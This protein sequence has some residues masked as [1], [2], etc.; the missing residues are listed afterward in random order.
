MKQEILGKAIFAGLIVLLFAWAAAGAPMRLG[1]DLQGGVKLMVK[2]DFELS[3]TEKADREGKERSE[4][5]YSSAERS[6]MMENLKAVL[7]RRLN[8]T[9][10]AEVSIRQRGKDKFQIEVPGANEAE[11]ERLRDVIERRGTLEFMLMA[12]NDPLTGEKIDASRFQDVTDPDELPVTAG[13]NAEPGWEDFI[14]KEADNP[15]DL[16][17]RLLGVHSVRY[18]PLIRP[19]KLEPKAEL[20]GRDL[21]LV[22]RT[23]DDTGAPAIAFRFNAEKSAIFGEITGKYGPKGETAGH[24]LA[25][26]VDGRIHS[27]PS[28]NSRIDGQGIIEGFAGEE[29]H[30]LLI[31]LRNG[32]LDV[33]LD[34]VSTSVIGPSLGAVQIKESYD[35]IVIGFVLVCI[36][37]ILY[38]RLSGIIAV[39]ALLAN[40]VIIVGTMKM[41]EATM[42]LPGIAGI[43]LTI[44]MSVDAN[45]LIYERVRE[46]LERGKTLRQA[47]INGY[48]RAFITIFDAN[49]TTLITAFILYQFGT[50][51]IRGFAVTLTIGILASMFT[52]LYC[53]RIIFDWLVSGRIISTLKMMRLFAESKIDFMRIKGLCIVG[54]IA[55]MLIGTLLMA[56]DGSS[57]LGIDFKGG[58]SLITHFKDPMRT[59][60]LRADLNAIKDENGQSKYK[61]LHITTSYDPD[62]T[63]TLEAGSARQFEI[64]M[65]SENLE[66]LEADLRNT[67][68]NELVPD[69]FLQ[70]PLRADGSEIEADAAGER[71]LPAKIKIRFDLLFQKQIGKDEIKGIIEKIDPR[72]ENAEIVVGAESVKGL[73]PVTLTTAELDLTQSF[74]G[75]N[76][77][78]ESNYQRTISSLFDGFK[79]AGIH[80]TGPFPSKELIGA[81][82]SSELFW[83]AAYSLILAILA[84]MIYIYFR[85]SEWKFGLAAVVALVHDIVITLGA[86]A[87][88]VAMA[89]TAIGQALGFGE[90]EINLPIVG[91]LL[92]I[93]GYSLNDTIVVFDRI[94][95]NAG[96]MRKQGLGAIINTSV[97]QT[98]S[99]TLLT[100]GTTF[101]TVLTLFLIGGK[102]IHDIS[103]ALCVGIVTGTYS[104]IFIASPI[105]VFWSPDLSKETSGSEAAAS[106]KAETATAGS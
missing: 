72:Y 58:S 103:F 29:L 9:G 6:E 68:E 55:V 61:G 44:G 30:N 53:T 51:P 81:E 2:A 14:F 73:F 65:L 66:G 85:F 75:R 101:L 71:S 79:D 74:K 63:D 3:L 8:A 89:D 10:L 76:D 56:Y 105:L 100:S 64:A 59:E 12:V 91:V 7:E 83:S 49:M 46:E 33:P 17:N 99:R 40:L 42:T 60:K 82:V 1:L 86:M 98:L 48:G 87:M 22:S 31:A 92:T 36:F 20:N 37:I 16:S 43:L 47:V 78:V 25:I 24:Q 27:A 70:T 104:S 95:E 39:I 45:I 5:S 93:I 19:D 4:V 57:M 15:N 28:I 23:M 18:Y 54:S 50:G 21:V 84:T 62:S 106:A 94:R 11:A 35:A 97:N 41:F 67:Y 13:A 38:Y 80:F 77:G 90:I 26:L 88:A 32:S 69:A 52:A 34:V 96:S 102:V